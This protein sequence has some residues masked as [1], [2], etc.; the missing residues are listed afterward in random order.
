MFDFEKSIGML[1]ELC[2]DYDKM[3]FSQVICLEKKLIVHF[4]KSRD[5]FYNINIKNTERGVDAILGYIE[6][7]G[8][9]LYWNTSTKVVRSGLREIRISDNLAA[10]VTRIFGDID[11]LLE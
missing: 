7:D 3:T 5:M 6:T 2:R 1:E 4:G 9:E 8:E 11:T 10:A